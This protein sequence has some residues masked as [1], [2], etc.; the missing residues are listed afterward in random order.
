MSK[1]FKVTMLMILVLTLVFGVGSVAYADVA[2]TLP[3]LPTFASAGLVIK[4]KNDPIPDTNPED[5]YTFPDGY[6][7]TGE[8]MIYVEINFDLTESDFCTAGTV[9]TNSEIYK[10]KYEEFYNEVYQDKYEEAY[11]A[12][13]ELWYSRWYYYWSIW[14]G[15]YGEEWVKRQADQSAVTNATQDAQDQANSYADAYA[16]EQ[17]A[18]YAV[19][20]ATDLKYVIREAYNQSVTYKTTDENGEEI[21][22]T[23]DAPRYPAIDETTVFTIPFTGAEY[24]NISLPTSSFPSACISQGKHVFDWWYENGN[25]C[26][27]FTEETLSGTYDINNA[28]IYFFDNLNEEKIAEED[29][30]EFVVG[31]PEEGNGD[32][33]TLELDKGWKLEKSGEMIYDASKANERDRYSAEYTVTLTFE[34]D[35]TLPLSITDTPGAY[36]GD[37]KKESVKLVDQPEGAN[38]SVTFEP[39]PGQ[40]GVFTF[41]TTNEDQVLPAGDYTFTYTADIKAEGKE[42]LAGDDPISFNDGTNNKNT[43]TL[44]D[45]DDIYAEDTVEYIPVPERIVEVEKAYEDG[46]NTPK[47]YLENGEYYVDYCI[48]V[49]LLYESN[50]FVV[51][52]TATGG[53][54]HTAEAPTL[55]Y[56]DDCA[57]AQAVTYP[58]TSTVDASNTTRTFTVSQEQTGAG[59]AD[60]NVLQ[61]G[62]YHLKYRMKIDSAAINNDL[63]NDAEAVMNNSAKV[64]HLNSTPLTKDPASTPEMEIPEVTV[65]K[66]YGTIKELNQEQYV[67]WTVTA[68]WPFPVA[69][70]TITDTIKN[71]EV[72]ISA[73]CPFSITNNGQQVVWLYQMPD[74][75]TDGLEITDTGFTYKMED[76]AS[77]NYTIT[78]W[79]KLPEGADKFAEQKITNAVDVDYDDDDDSDGAADQA[80]TLDP[81]VQVF[82][83]TKTA[84][85]VNNATSTVDYT[86]VVTVKYDQELPLTVKDVPGAFIGAP[87]DLTLSNQPNGANASITT[88]GVKDEDGAYTFTFGTDNEDG[89]LKAGSYTI[90]Y[91]AELTEE[92]KTALASN[93][94]NGSEDSKNT[95]DLY[96]D[97]ED[98]VTETAIGV[99]TYIPDTDTVT[100]A[101]Y[102]N[103]NSHGGNVYAETVDGKTSYYIDYYIDVTMP[104]DGESFVVADSATEGGMVHADEAPT[105]EYYDLNWQGQTTGAVLTYTD[106][107]DGTVRTFTITAPD[108]SKLTAGVYRIKYR[109]NVDAAVATMLQNGEDVIV[110]NSA[111]LTKVDDEL[112]EKDPVNPGDVTIPAVSLT[113]SVRETR[114]YYEDGAYAGKLICW[115]MYYQWQFAEAGAKIVDTW[116]DNTELYIDSNCHFVIANNSSDLL[117]MD[118]PNDALI[119]G[120]TFTDNGFE[121]VLGSVNEDTGKQYRI[122][123][124]TKTTGDIYADQKVTNKVTVDGEGPEATY[125][126]PGKD[127]P[128]PSITKAGAVVDGTLDETTGE[129]DIDWTVTVDLKDMAFDKLESLSIDDVPQTNPYLELTGVKSVKLVDANGNETTLQKNTHYTVSETTDGTTY[130]YN[131]V[132]Y[133]RKG[134]KVTLDLTQVTLSENMKVVVVY[135]SHATRV[136]QYNSSQNYYNKAVVNYKYTGKDAESLTAETR[137]SETLATASLTKHLRNN[138][139]NQLAYELEFINSEFKNTEREQIT[140]TVKDEMPTYTLAD[141]TVI[142]LFYIDYSSVVVSSNNMYNNYNPQYLTPDLSGKQNNAEGDFTFS[143][144]VNVPANW[145]QDTVWV[146]YNIKPSNALRKYFKGNVNFNRWEGRGEIVNK[147]TIE[148]GDGLSRSD[149]NSTQFG[150]TDDRLDK[151]LSLIGESTSGSTVYARGVQYTITINPHGAMLNGGAETLMVKDV[152][153][154]GIDYLEY[155][156]SETSFTVTA[157]DADGA[158]KLARALYASDNTYAVTFTRNDDNEA[159]GFTLSVPNGKK[160]VLTY[161]ANLRASVPYGQNIGSVV[162][163]AELD[164]ITSEE[165]HSGFQKST[166]GSS[167]SVST[168]CT[169]SIKKIERE[170]SGELDIKGA[171]FSAYLVG[172]DGSVGTTAIATGTTNSKGETSFVFAGDDYDVYNSVFVIRETAAAPGYQLPADQAEMYFY[173]AEQQTNAAGDIIGYADPTET[174]QTI[175]NALTAAGKTVLRIQ[176]ENNAYT[177]VVTNTWAGFDFSFTKVDEAGAVL[178]GAEFELTDVYDAPVA[179]AKDGSE[180]GVFSWS[181]LRPGTYTLTETVAPEGFDLP[182]E[183]WTITIG[184]DGKITTNIPQVDGAYTITNKEST[185]PFTFTKVDEDSVALAGATFTLTNADGEVLTVTSG[186]DGV[187]LFEELK[188]G[189]YTLTE[190]VVPEGYEPA[191]DTTW[192]VVIAK[193][194]TITVDG[195]ALP[196]GGYTVANKKLEYLP[197]AAEISAKK[198]LTNAADMADDQSFTF[199]FVL[200]DLNDA[201]LA[202]GYELTVEED[203]EVSFTKVSADQTVSLGSINFKKAGT[204]T[205]KVSEAEGT[206]TGYITYATNVYYLKYVVEQPAADATDKTLLVTL[207]VYDNEAMAGDPVQT[208]TDATFDAAFTNT[209]ETVSISGAKVWADEENKFGLR[210]ESITIKLL[211][212]GVATGDTVTLT[213]TTEGE[214]ESAVKTWPAD[215]AFTNLPKYDADG[216]EIAYTAEEETVSGY[217][218]TYSEDGM[219]I[220]NTLKKAETSF[221]IRK[222]IN[223]FDAET[224]P[225]ETFTFTVVPQESYAGKLTFANADYSAE[226]AFTVSVLGN[227][228]EI[229]TVLDMSIFEAGTYVFTITEDIPQ[230]Y[231]YWEYDTETLTVTIKVSAE[232]DGTLT[233]PVVTYRKGELSDYEEPWN[234]Y[235]RYGSAR[236]SGFKRWTSYNGETFKDL[237]SMLKLYWRTEKTATQPDYGPWQAYTGPAYTITFKDKSSEGS[238]EAEWWI[239]IEGLPEYINGQYVQYG[240]AEIGAD[241][242]YNVTYGDDESEITTTAD[243]IPVINYG[244]TIFNELKYVDVPVVKVW[245]DSSNAYLTRPDSV[246]LTLEV[247]YTDA[248]GQTVTLDNGTPDAY[249][250][251]LSAESDEDDTDGDDRWSYTW[252]GLDK[253]IELDG[254]RYA[255]TYTPKEVEVSPLYFSWESEDDNGVINNTL[256]TV[257][258]FFY[259]LWSDGNP[260]GI[261][262]AFTLKKMNADGEIVDLD[263]EVSKPIYI[264]SRDHYMYSGL[265]K[266]ELDADGNA[267]EIQYVVVEDSVDGYE[268]VYYRRGDDPEVLEHGTVGVNKP[269]NIANVKLTEISGTKV[270]DDEDNALGL[271]PESITIKLLADGTEKE[272]KTVTPDDDGNWT[273]EFTDLPMH[274]LNPVGYVVTDD[275][276]NPVE[277]VYTVEEEAVYGYTTSYSADTLTITNTRNKVET[278]FG[279][280][281]YIRSVTDGSDI[282]PKNFVF[283]VTPQDDYTGKLAFTDENYS[284]AEAFEVTVNGDTLAK[285]IRTT[286]EL[287]AYEEG[288]YEFTVSE[289]D[290]VTPPD[291]WLYD[292]ETMTVTIEVARDSADGTLLDPYVTY[293]KGGVKGYAEPLMFTNDYAIADFGAYKEWTTYNGEENIDLELYYRTQTY[294]VETKTYSYGEWTEYGKDYEVTLVKPEQ[295]ETG[296]TVTW[297]IQIADLPSFI[298]GVEVEYGI[299]EVGADSDYTI[300]YKDGKGNLITEDANGLRVIPHGGTI[301]NTYTKTSLTIAKAWED[302]LEPIYISDYLKVYTLDDEANPVLLD[303]Q[304]AAP[305]YTKGEDGEPDSYTWTDLAKYDENDVEIRYVVIED[306]LEGV[307]PNYES[308]LSYAGDGSTITNRGAESEFRISKSIQMN[309]TPA[310]LLDSYEFSFTLTPDSGN[311]ATPSKVEVVDDEGATIETL[312]PDASGVYTVKLTLTGTD[313]AYTKAAETIRLTFPKAGEYAFTLKE[314]VPEQYPDNWVYCEDEFTFS[315]TVDKNGSVSKAGTLSSSFT[316][317]VYGNTEL[318]ISKEWADDGNV[319]GKRPEA[320]EF[321]SCLTLRY[322]VNGTDEWIEY[323]AGS[324]PALTVNADNSDIWEI[325]YEDLPQYIGGEEVI[326]S[327]V[328]DDIPTYSKTYDYAETADCALHHIK[329]TSELVSVE[330]TKIWTHGSNPEANRPAEDVT[331]K[332]QLYIKNGETETLVKND[333][334]TAL[335][336]VRSESSN[337]VAE[338]SWHG[339]DKL[340]EGQEYIVKETEVPDGYIVRY[341]DGKKEYVVNGKN[342][343]NEFFE[344]EAEFFGIKLMDFDYPAEGAFTFE[345]VQ[346]DKNGDPIEPPVATAVNDADGEF[347]IKIA[348]GIDDIGK[349]YDYIIR[350]KKGTESDVFYDDTEYGYQVTITEDGADVQSDAGAYALFMNY[351]T[352]SVQVT[353]VWDGGAPADADISDKLTLWIDISDMLSGESEETILSFD[354]LAEE[355]SIEA[356]FTKDGDVYTW[357]NLPVGIDL[358]SGEIYAFKYVVTEEAVDG[359]VTTYEQLVDGKLVPAEDGANNGG[360]IT[361]AKH[362]GEAT[363]NLAKS[364][365]VQDGV[366]APETGFEFILKPASDNWDNVCIYQDDKLLTP[367]ADKSY[368]I[369]VELEEVLDDNGQRA[370]YFYKLESLKLVF[371]AADTYTMTVQEVVPEQAEDGWQYDQHVFDVTFT[372]VANETNTGYDVTPGLDETPDFYNYYTMPADFA[373]NKVWADDNDADGKRPELNPDSA[374]FTAWLNSLVLQYRSVTAD[375]AGE[376]FYGE[377]TAYPGVVPTVKAADADTWTITYADLPGVIN[378]EQVEWSVYE[379]PGAAKDY[380]GDHVGEDDPAFEGDSITNTLNITKFSGTKTWQDQDDKYGTRPESI[381]IKLLADGEQ[382]DSKTVKPDADGNW[383]WEFTELPKYQLDEN[384]RIK[385]A[386]GKPVEIAYTFEEVEVPGYEVITEDGITLVNVLVTTGIEGTKVWDDKGKEVEHD[387]ITIWLLADGIKT[388]Q[389]VKLA[390]GETEWSFTDLPMYQADGQTKVIYTVAEDPV[391]DYVTTYSEDTLTITNTRYT[392]TGEIVLEGTKVLTGRAQEAGEFTFV[393]K[394]ESSNTVSTGTNDEKGNIVFTAI[395]Y[396]QDD[397]KNGPIKYTISEEK[398]E[399]AT[400][401]YDGNDVKVTVTLTDDGKGTITATPDKAKTEITFTNKYEVEGELSLT[402]TKTLDGRTLEDE[403]FEFTLT[404]DGQNQVKKNTGNV[405]VFDSIQYTQDDIGKSFTYIVAEKAGDNDAYTYDSTTYTVAVSV[406]A[407][408]GALKVNYTVDGEAGKTMAFENSYEAAGEITFAGEKTLEGRELEAGEFTFEVTEEGTENKWTVSHKADGTIEYPTITYEQG[409]VGTHTYTVRETSEAGNGVTVDDTEYTVKVEVTDDGEGNLT[410]MVLEGSDDH[411]A[412]DFKNTYE[413]STDITLSGVKSL[414]GR[415]LKDDEFSFKLYRV[416]EDGETYLAEATNQDGAFTFDKITYT[417]EDADKTYTYNVYEVNGALNGVT[418]VEEPV[419]VTVTITD[420]G[421]GTLTATADKNGEGIAFVNTYEASGKIK[422]GGTKLLVGRNFRQGDSFTFELYEGDTLL[423]TVTINPTAEDGASKTFEFKTID[424]AMS[425]EDEQTHIYTIKERVPEALAEDGSK[426]GVTYD[427]NAFTVTVEVKDNGKGNLVAEIVTEESDKVEFKNTYEASASL[428]LQAL[429]TVNGDEPSAEQ[430]YDFVMEGNGEKLEAKNDETGLVTFET[431]YF[432]L[433]DVGNTYTYTIK[434]TTEATELLAVDESIYTLT[435]TV[436]DNGD[437]TLNLNPVLAKEG[438]TVEAV[439]FDNRTLAHLT[440][441]KMVKGLKTDEAFD[442]I[443]S[444]FD[445]D[446]KELS[447]EYE[448]TGDVNGKVV[449]GGK[450]ALKDGQT[451]IIKGLPEGATYKVQEN[452]SKAY[453]TTVNGKSG[454]EAEGLLVGSDNHV[455]FINTMEITDFSVTKVWDGEDLGAIILTLYANGVEIVPQPEVTR[456]GNKY[457]YSDLPKYDEDGDEIVYSAKERYFDGYITI[458]KNVS[459]YTDMTKAIY[460]GGTIINREKEEVKVSFQIKK[461]WSGLQDGET[462]PDITLTLYCNGEVVEGVSTPKPDSDGWYK[463]YDLPTSV[464]GEIA[465]YTVMEA[466]LPGYTTIYKD[467]NGEIVEQGVN[468]GEIVNT[469]IPQTGDSASLGLWLAMMGAS[470]AM[471]AML[472]RRKRA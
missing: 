145:N 396:T 175:I 19:E 159:V 71:G 279:F 90:T 67:Q 376:V 121:Y 215:W 434:E 91:T 364:L 328:E 195:D 27:R 149:D 160:I 55:Y 74:G 317:N 134:L 7:F 379:K 5:Y 285:S 125:D 78:Y 298:G 45:K 260:D 174:Q 219:T 130:W 157:Y 295:A 58:V 93:S 278:S 380:I 297:E 62:T 111:D 373:V 249:Q 183:A 141:G 65:T 136:D 221:T 73:D 126:I 15:D 391:A 383:A 438:E 469:R 205:F 162:N 228:A 450:I 274:K 240:M 417:Q 355:W 50:S 96:T 336:P 230:E 382:T 313:G 445:A 466:S 381:T 118:D 114:D 468:G 117:R 209:Y 354:E 277:I 232:D 47:V 153:T 100:I 189:T 386:D 79:T 436:S 427:E 321:L 416:D 16:S 57:S 128:A 356:V 252:T 267:V 56:G 268:T 395:Q 426:D 11:E 212:D 420:D 304:P 343:Y 250:I 107:D 218:T 179:A 372:A 30:L 259:K 454:T 271:R 203:A 418:Y 365:Y 287:T 363:L 329:N 21:V 310:G 2:T 140:I 256:Y 51:E 332:L 84:G 177:A 361:N 244:D 375:E 367:K 1:L 204:Y 345:L 316:N 61:P 272:S 155:D 314:S 378:G 319:A 311:T 326:W 94:F 296:E 44:T 38:A 103:W 283:V 110:G 394:D 169:V 35:V 357:S 429:K 453:T 146:R 412:L 180:D 156:T 333:E 242:K 227:A 150:F 433:S 245:D 135:S 447:G 17:A 346:L 147:A 330:V 31:T 29:E 143:F 66:T 324:A 430:V 243:G 264:S 309:G 331:T 322:K 199:G 10:Q 158:T 46:S 432:D 23:L 360:V 213:A 207:Y 164:G 123:Y 165:S 467:A 318:I 384:G 446:G 41:S 294:D 422:L 172:T 289:K 182:E 95:A 302:G 20:G 409:D 229:D 237:E 338:Y 340:P 69:D 81:L 33:E 291:G 72:F 461:T 63:D 98:P 231:Y 312:E 371:F 208:V 52:D 233:A 64:T 220:V 210:P 53:L 392:S 22:E 265:P 320:D 246:T 369:P 362:R 387:D 439:T 34:R 413:T 129:M 87:T 191:G 344:A 184:E 37:P 148:W 388:E 305:T 425:E 441:S 276:G 4:N 258:L 26:I 181:E 224:T 402:A 188:A 306:S 234:F 222:T 32:S 132:Q 290:A 190:T 266:H 472:L 142:P 399:D 68:N 457:T 12:A 374:D 235:N 116:S 335:Q 440:I 254:E 173:F 257:Q 170:D 337:G 216:S 6:E 86:I 347:E 463:Y 301:T 280:D 42:V 352:T 286:L 451:V 200:E 448:Y 401:D 119:A 76:V 39:T 36:I 275:D 342:I 300:T 414:E 161:V 163:K 8:E 385:M 152:M 460:D 192:E 404:G 262:P 459:P 284:V 168:E 178:T 397:V 197:V 437:G 85:T 236:F 139:N 464:D 449:S 113:K 327:V 196:E 435:L 443:V 185:W 186:E 239:R 25:I 281:K 194:G 462:A 419:T 193:D 131:N 293:S 350:E 348:Y 198:T 137:V 82:T 292:A 176:D 299:A 351:T 88:D 339:L 238:D 423:D 28:S 206:D 112:V 144:D 80:V 359:Y 315:F 171:Q 151:S 253:Y 398:G 13:Y 393:V 471:L 187:V 83:L 370:G 366:D 108:G 410:A 18:K 282:L 48:E 49:E 54:L 442:M 166:V 154:A 263:F 390:N 307:F 288:T 261:E 127:L 406:T 415:E 308:G 465:V 115:E 377:W 444:F 14:T 424:F 3:L 325:V 59:P 77:G 106:N 43:V 102:R 124:W 428:M 120:L 104:Y 353:K 431:L 389:F 217:A 122:A 214:G 368:T 358:G 247:S 133:E 24:V 9:D 269:L 411:E 201:E 101:K 452:V 60:V 226:K 223:G 75:E 334:G 458:Y 408:N 167:V 303:P 421:K 241:G 97:E 455:D 349:T 109:M 225:E 251:E 202:A 255:L 407:E 405:V 40:P 92:G 70:G 211:A 138:S 89:V 400:V 341:D 273:F 323:D 99:P 470:A 248:D 456:V 403:Q 270:W 105:L